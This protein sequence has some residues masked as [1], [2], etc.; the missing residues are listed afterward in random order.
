M[1]GLEWAFTWDGTTGAWVSITWIQ[2]RVLEQD[3]TTFEPSSDFPHFELLFS[4][5]RAAMVEGRAGT[6]TRVP[7]G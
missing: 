6:E 1:D 5:P 4:T 7:S 3:E 2:V